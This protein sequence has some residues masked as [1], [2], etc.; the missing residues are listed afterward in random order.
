MSE[1]LRDLAEYSKILRMHEKRSFCANSDTLAVLARNLFF[2][3]AQNSI[4][5]D[6]LKTFTSSELLLKCHNLEKTLFFVHA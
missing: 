2:V 3:H 6:S 4:V 1:K 5:L